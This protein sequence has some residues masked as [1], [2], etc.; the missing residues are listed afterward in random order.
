M[1]SACSNKNITEARFIGLA[2]M[3]SFVLLCGYSENSNS[4]LNKVMWIDI[5]ALG[6]LLLDWLL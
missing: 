4:A 5:A 2:S 6:L 3:G 1:Y